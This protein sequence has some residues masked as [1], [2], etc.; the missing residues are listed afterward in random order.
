MNEDII[1]A[2]YIK[3]K[4]MTADNRWDEDIEE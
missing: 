2:P 3:N 4:N 1:Y